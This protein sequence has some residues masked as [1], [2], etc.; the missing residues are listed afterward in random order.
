M[1][2]PNRALQAVH[3]RHENT[4]IALPGFTSKPE[5]YYGHCE[6]EE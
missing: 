5:Q 4:L 1:E 2:L 3:T 6:I